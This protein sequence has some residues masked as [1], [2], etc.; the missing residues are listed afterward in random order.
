[1]KRTVAINTKPGMD[2]V[3]IT[4]DVRKAVDESG[5]KSGIVNVFVA[6]STASIS[7]MEY[8]PNLVEDIREAMEKIAPEKKGYRHH[9]T[10]GDHNGHSHVRSALMGPNITV[11]FEN[12]KLLLGTWQQIVLLD[13]D[14]PAR[15]RKITITVMGNK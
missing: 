10:W 14:V 12:G 8:E 7:T 1:M 9:E 11:P 4:D 2:I 3:D 15:E 13:F 6:G 5:A